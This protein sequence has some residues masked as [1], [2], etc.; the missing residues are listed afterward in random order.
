MQNV[1]LNLKAARYTR[2]A[3]FRT[4]RPLMMFTGHCALFLAVIYS[5]VRLAAAW[6]AFDPVSTKWTTEEHDRDP[7]YPTRSK[8]WAGNVQSAPEF[9]TNLKY[10]T[11]RPQT[12]TKRAHMSLVLPD[13]RAA[14]F[15]HRGQITGHATGR[16]TRW[17]EIMQMVRDC[18]LRSVPELFI[19]FQPTP[20]RR[21]PIPATAVSVAPVLRTT[22][23]TQ[24]IQLNC[25][26]SKRLVP[27]DIDIAGRCQLENNDRRISL[28]SSTADAVSFAPGVPEVCVPAY[29][30][31]LNELRNSR[32]GTTNTT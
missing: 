23:T 31:L 3:K 13:I 20:S 18:P 26:R 11:A 29:R 6:R 7:V 24:C 1:Q 12:L 4:R 27:P 8:R 9:V 10:P 15:L 19:I 21:S 5:G 28:A 30:S 17:L 16:A 25:T 32:T 14:E 2:H 22:N